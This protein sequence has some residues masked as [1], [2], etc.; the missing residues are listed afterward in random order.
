MTDPDG[1]TSA[2]EDQSGAMGLLNGDDL[3]NTELL[4]TE[5]QHKPLRDWFGARQIDT[6]ADL[7]AV[8]TTGYFDEAAMAIGEQHGLLAELI[9]QVRYAYRQNFSWV[10]LSLAKH[11]RADRQRILDFFRQL[12]GHTLF[13][14]YV[15]KKQT[16]DLELDR[17]STRLNSS[18]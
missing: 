3:S 4:A 15:V 13:T 2:A 11:G 1:E 16:Q 14:R 12:Y 10:K 8:D 7:S 9:E 5:A 18:H 6:T 17:K